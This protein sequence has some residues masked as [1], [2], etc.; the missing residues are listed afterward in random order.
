MRRRGRECALQILYQMDVNRELENNG[1]KV[2]VDKA[3]NYFWQSFENVDEEDRNFAE[4]LIRGVTANLH[5]LD[6]AI[7][8]VSQNWRVAR[9]GKVD[10]CLIRVAAYEILYCPDIP[11]VVSINEAVEIAKRFS[12]KESAA[13]VNGI[14]DQVGGSENT[15][16]NQAI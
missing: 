1:Q 14:L 4:C 16:S 13:F 9:M 2:N 3:I 5:D 6:E 8:K 15:G 12:G 7:A 11:R 10:R